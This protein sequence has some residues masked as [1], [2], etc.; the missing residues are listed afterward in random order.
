MVTGG[1]AFPLFSFFDIDQQFGVAQYAINNNNDFPIYLTQLTITDNFN[2]SK[3]MNDPRNMTPTGIPSNLLEPFTK[4]YEL[5]ELMPRNALN[6]N[7]F[8]FALKEG[9]SY[10]LITSARNGTFVQ[11]IVAHKHNNGWL[12]A[13][14]VVNA[15]NDNK[16]IFEAI[17]DNFP[18]ELLKW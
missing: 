17:P 3:V 13:Q 7:T 8:P 14:K 15:M 5:G 11:I 2:S 18:K 16:I 9:H 4:R 6:L 1:D 10:S 12:L